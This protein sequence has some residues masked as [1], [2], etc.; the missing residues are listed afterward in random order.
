MIFSCLR[1]CGLASR[2]FIIP[3]YSTPLR[4][5]QTCVRAAAWE[6]VQLNVSRYYMMSKLLFLMVYSFP[7]RARKRLKIQR[8]GARYIECFARY[9]NTIACRLGGTATQ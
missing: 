6:Y 9:D 3:A 1:C 7:D 4:P 5:H 8:C 2:V